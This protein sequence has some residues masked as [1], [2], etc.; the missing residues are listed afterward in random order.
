[1]TRT[2]PPETLTACVIVRDEE[3]RLPACLE[4]LSFCD[5]VVVVDSGSRDRTREIAAEAGAQVFES[6][7]RGFAAQRN[8]AL[9]RASGSWVLE[10]DA[11]ERVSPELAAEMRALLDDPPAGVRMAAI[12]MRDLF[13]GRPLGPSARYPRYRHRLFRRGA[14]RHDESRTVHEGLWPDGPTVPLKGDCGTC[15]PPRG[16]RR[17]ATPGPMPG[18]KPRSGRARG[19]AKR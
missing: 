15:S 18:S 13:L 12:P 16:G 4:S 6:P 3:G 7:W 11:D 9:D 14:F 10:V 19:R 5:E 8:V 2:A 1:M 17:C